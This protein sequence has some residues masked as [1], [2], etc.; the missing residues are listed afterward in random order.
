MSSATIWS[1]MIRIGILVGIF[2]LFVF[3]SAGTFDWLEAWACLLLVFIISEAIV[4]YFWKYDRELL[5]S[6]GSFNQ[7]K[8]KWD[9]ILLVLLTISL[10]AI[11]IV[12]GLDFRFD[13]SNIPEIIS[14]GAFGLVIIGLSIYFL[15]LKENTYASKVVE[16]REDQQVIFTGPYKYVRHPLY[17]GGSIAVIGVALSLGSLYA[18][19]PAL[20]FII[21]LI[22]RL[23]LEEK[24][25]EEELQEY[26][27][28]K[29]KVRYRLIPYL[30]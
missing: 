1:L 19:V 4:I 5:Q 17:L 16:V 10:F 15:V 9:I 24:T 20:I 26:N 6:R 7:T 18:L 14:I 28:Y 3:I 13:L 21:L 23:I 29:K 8:E 30:W 2:G 27:E 25:L 12:A 11:P 22:I